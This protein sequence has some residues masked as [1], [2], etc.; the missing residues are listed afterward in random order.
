[1]NNPIADKKN[2]GRSHRSG[3][4]ISVQRLF[5]GLS[6]RDTDW[7]EVDSPYRRSVSFRDGNRKSKSNSIA[8]GFRVVRNKS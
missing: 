3:H 5:E 7:S 1:M 4:Y 6:E 2:L 8:I